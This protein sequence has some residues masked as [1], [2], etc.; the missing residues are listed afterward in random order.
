MQVF[1]HRTNPGG[2]YLTAQVDHF[3]GL[4]AILR[5]DFAKMDRFLSAFDD[6]NNDGYINFGLSAEELDYYKKAQ[7]VEYVQEKMP[8]YA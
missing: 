1:A 4:K 8:I 3:E 6:A 2:F 5:R 7:A